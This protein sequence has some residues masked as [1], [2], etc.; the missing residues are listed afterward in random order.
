MR[1]G[2]DVVDNVDKLD[3][4]IGGKFDEKFDYITLFHVL[5][6]LKDP[7]QLL[8]KLE[9]KLTDSGEIIIEVP[10]ADDALITIY[11]N[12]WFMSFVFWSC[13]LFVFN[14]HTLL[15]LVEKAGFKVNYIKHVQRYGLC[16]HFWWQFFKKPG[17]HKKLWFLNW[18]FIN[19]WYEKS[20]ASLNATDTIIVSISRNDT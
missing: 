8:K 1:N 4:K 19:R 2:L 18:G 11:N 3:E 12:Y 13:H 5:E 10:N 20:L 16:N 7:I 15:N 9:T 6:H 17:G 14:A